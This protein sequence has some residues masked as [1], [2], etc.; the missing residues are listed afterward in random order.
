MRMRQKT[1]KITF[2]TSD[3]AKLTCKTPINSKN[4][5]KWQ[6]LKK[7]FSTLQKLTGLSAY[8]RFQTVSIF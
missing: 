5:C 6:N 1:R 7:I 2:L 8:L 4:D 3:F